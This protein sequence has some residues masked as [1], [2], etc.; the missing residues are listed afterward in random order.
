MHLTGFILFL[1]LAAGLPASKFIQKPDC[2]RVNAEISVSSDESGSIV[3]IQPAGGTRP[4]RIIVFEPGG[5]LISEDFRRQTFSGVA[6]GDYT[7]VIIDGEN[8]RKT[9]DFKVP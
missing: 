4:Y 8:C 7:C 6:S 3:K 2:Q 5:R 1:F 9:I